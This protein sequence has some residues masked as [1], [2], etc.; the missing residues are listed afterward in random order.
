MPG[1]DDLEPFDINESNFIDKEPSEIKGVSNLPTSNPN[2]AKVVGQGNANVKTLYNPY[3]KG[4]YNPNDLNDPNHP[5]NLKNTQS[6]VGFNVDA[7]AEFAKEDK[8]QK[9]IEKYY[10]TEGTNL[11]G[12]LTT[13]KSINDA[14][15][16]D[17][18]TS[19]GIGQTYDVDENLNEKYRL[20][21]YDESEEN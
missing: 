15:G 12:N 17:M 9:E 19:M 11:D 8:K 20:G 6:S 5:N 13:S 1:N 16:K 10:A 18:S 4:Y 7:F 2:T 3:T 21:I 14:Y